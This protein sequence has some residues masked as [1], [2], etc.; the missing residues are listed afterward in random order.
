MVCSK[1]STYLENGYLLIQYCKSKDINLRNKIVEQNMGLVYKVAHKMV[2]YCQLPFEELVQIGSGGLIKAVE[3]FNP[4]KKRKFSSLAVPFIQGAILQWLRDKGRLVK[5]PSNLQETHQK[6]KRYAREEE[7][8]YGDAALELGISDELAEEALVASV[9]HMQELPFGLCNETS[10]E[11]FEWEPL[12]SQLPSQYAAVIND[13]YLE[14]ISI[15]EVARKH[16]FKLAEIKRIEDEGIKLLRLIAQGRIKC[17]NCNN[18]ETIKNGKRNGKQSYLCKSC[19]H[20]FV[21]NPLPIGRRGY[22]DD[23]KHKVL[24]HIQ[25]G[26]SLHWCENYYKVDHSTVYLWVKKYGI[27]G[28]K[29]SRKVMTTPVQQQ[30]Q[31][32]SKFNNLAEWLSKNCSSSDD[33]DNAL[34]LLKQS[35]HHSQEAIGREKK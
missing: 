25:E 17:P 24:S 13:I 8:S 31:L 27:K 5:V 11:L 1:T 2:H 30:W 14:A 19:N 35:M 3:R 10:D 21:E 9:Q 32:I 4:S 22:C 23:V 26:K 6:I 29:V 15:R 18:Y 16:S 7:I 12:L 33:L 20:Q 34:D 28:R